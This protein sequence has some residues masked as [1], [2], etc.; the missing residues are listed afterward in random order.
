M[1]QVAEMK[2]S[3]LD[4]VPINDRTI[5][6]NFILEKTYD[7][8]KNLFINKYLSLFTSKRYSDLNKEFDEMNL[9]RSIENKIIAIKKYYRLDEKD[10][11]EFLLASIPPSISDLFYASKMFKTIN[12][13]KTFSKVLDAH[14]PTANDSLHNS[15]LSAQPESEGFAS[16]SLSLVEQAGKER[17][18]KSNQLHRLFLDVRNKE[19]KDNESIDSS[20]CDSSLNSDDKVIENR[21]NLSN[22]A[23]KES[24]AK[25]S[26][27][28][29]DKSEA[30]CSSNLKKK[31]GNKISTSSNKAGKRSND[32]DEII[33]NKKRYKT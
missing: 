7:E 14:D 24:N 33:G 11:P 27:C 31:K 18:N 21:N 13:I 9:E 10:V 6:A 16:T 32:S 8:V 28:T 3:I 5:F 30:I 19:D 29:D 20:D 26:K 22:N 12:Q 25:K 23:S 2:S 1:D 4:F 17:S 15:T